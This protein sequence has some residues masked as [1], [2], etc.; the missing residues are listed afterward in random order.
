MSYTTKFSLPPGICPEIWTK[1]TDFGPFK[2][3][4]LWNLSEINGPGECCLK[5]WTTKSPS[6]SRKEALFLAF[7]GFFGSQSKNYLWTPSLCQATNQKSRSSKL[8]WIEWITSIL[9]TK[10]QFFGQVL[11][12]MAF[13][14]TAREVDRLSSTSTKNEGLLDTWPFP[15]QTPSLFRPK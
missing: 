13:S 10:K 7:A 4:K 2:N 8:T 11:E 12:S 1:S 9:G 3:R 15:T 14:N 6:G 5:I